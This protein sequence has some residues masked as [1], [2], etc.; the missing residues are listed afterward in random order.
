MKKIIIPIGA[1][2][3]SSTTYAQLSTVENYVYSKTYLDY[4]GNTPTKSTETVQYYDGLGR[5]KQTVNIK[6]SPLEKDV[7][8]PIVYDGYGKKTREYLPVPQQSTNA[9]AIYPQTSGDFP[10]GDPTSAYTN[11]KAF[12]EKILERSPLD[13]ILQQKQVGIAWHDKP[14]QFGYDT[15]TT[16]D[17]VKKYTTV[18]NWENAA[19]I[20]TVS[21]T[22]NYGAAQ[23][24]KNTVTDED[25]NITIEFKNGE[26]QILLVRKVI[27]ATENAD[28]YYVYNE[29]NQLAF[30]IPPKAAVVL[31]PNSVLSDLCYQYRYDSWNRMAEKKVP[32]KGWEYMIYDKQDR[33]VMSQDANMGLSRQWLFTK[34][35][36]FGRSV[37]TGIYISS[38][39]YESAGRKAEQTIVDSKGSNNVERLSTTGFTN[40][41]MDVYYSNDVN[42]SYPNSI[43]K[44]LSVS[45]YDSYPVGT[46]TV[47]LQVLGQEVLSQDSQ[48]SSMSTKSLP[49]ASYIKN[50]EDD[51][52]TKNYTYYDKKGRTISTYSIN[53]LGG[54]TKVDSKL[55]FTGI[56][57]QSITTHKRLDTGTDKVITENFTYDPQNRL[58]TRTHQVDSNPVEYLTQNTYNELS[59][60]TNKKVGGITPF[61]SL[62]DITYSYNI[63]GWMTKINNPKNLNGKLFGYEIKYNQVEGEQT[64]DPFDTSLQVLPKYNGNIAEVDWKTSTI[65]NDYL[66]RYGYVYDKLN[67]LSAGFYEREDNPSAREYFEKMTYDLNGN[68]INLKRTGSL[69]GNTTSVLIDNLTYE[70]FNNNNSNRLN[71]ITE[72]QQNLSGY[73]YEVTP[74]AIV[75][76][77]NGNMTI[78]ADKGY[79]DISYNYLNLP[80]TFLFKNGLS[81]RTGIIR[82][83][84][85]NLYRADGIKL[86]KTYNFAPFNPLGI[87]TKLSSKVTEY[88]DSFQYESEMGGKSGVTTNLMLRFVPTAEGY[89]NFENNKYIYNYTDHL[90]NV[91]LS[92]FN[93]GNGIEVL[94]ENNYYPFGMKH[95]GYNTLAGNPTY[96]YSYNGKELQTDSGMYDYGA[97]MYMADIGRWGVIDPLSDKMRRHSP[98]NYAFDNPIRFIDP[99]GRAP[100]DDFRIY[101]DGRKELIRHTKDKFDRYYNQ[102]GSKSIKVSKEFTK[103][104]KQNVEWAP[105]R[106][107]YPTETNIVLENPD[108]SSKQIK[109]YYY[110]LAANTSKEWS[111]DKLSKEGIFGDTTLYLIR[112]QHRAE[113]AN[114]HGVAA[115]LARNKGYTWLETGHDHPM[116]TLMRESTTYE[117]NWPSGFNRDG[118]L[119]SDSGD[120][121]TYE[122]DKDVMPDKAW[123]FIPTQKHPNMIYYN[124][125]RFWFPNQNKENV[126]Q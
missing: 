80:S 56:V 32:G 10:V 124:D 1:L 37:Y 54:R 100:K 43:S 28:T 102:N 89:Y 42:T 74:S 45:Y 53:H 62:Q 33:L 59:Q 4:N 103:N 94:E 41:G 26:G 20:S 87:I 73:P 18:T 112:S 40:S 48:N 13:R 71:K 15:N 95:E 66:R 19:T 2:L 96:K 107:Y 120:R 65:S 16:G 77:D 111:F 31:D 81:T 84:T 115:D 121:K 12:S 106:G 46:P 25:G 14:V 34:Y 30:V 97:R 57:Q 68:I 105:F 118:T 114:D 72:G 35:D 123:I 50:I 109:N 125:Q 122:Q 88:L 52:W 86:R 38:Q 63:R 75:Y 126:H 64:P 5:P 69:D 78:N 44:L 110:F 82:E 7:V 70:Y 104:F 91:R 79:L 116:G 76:D 9:G 58:L 29:F 119:N 22:I 21:Q 101:V 60:V 47:P 113:D 92:Y 39:N 117:N 3:F 55:D 49:V 61:I 99:D 27:S 6:T 83:N 36:Q 23:L 93:N 108:I 51:N 98:Y 67:R 17:A 24:Y 8:I 90:G 85:S 11:E